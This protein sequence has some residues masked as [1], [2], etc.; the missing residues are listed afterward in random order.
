MILPVEELWI[1]CETQLDYTCH[2]YQNFLCVH[3][4]HGTYCETR[5]TPL[6]QSACPSYKMTARLKLIDS[7]VIP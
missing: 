5:T 6:F 4:D 7:G 2:Y 3:P 1:E